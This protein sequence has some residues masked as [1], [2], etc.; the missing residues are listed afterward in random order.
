MCRR[1]SDR[2][3]R[4]AWNHYQTTDIYVLIVCTYFIKWMHL[5]EDIPTNCFNLRA[6]LMCSSRHTIDFVRLLLAWDRLLALS[7]SPSSHFLPVPPFICTVRR[8]LALARFRRCRSPVE[9]HWMIEIAIFVQLNCGVYAVAS[10][11]S[12]RLP[13]DPI[14][15]FLPISV[16]VGNVTLNVAHFTE[17]RFS[18]F[19]SHDVRR[20]VTAVYMQ[21]CT[22]VLTSSFLAIVISLCEWKTR[23]TI[24]IRKSEEIIVRVGSLIH[25]VCTSSAHG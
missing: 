9:A 11:F 4:R 6:V 21:V 18:I 14:R 8:V 13:I 22:T 7:V 12:L 15:S 1:P 2:R 23:K 17:F 16:L 10:L 19:T 25:A 20:I 24:L 3:C 5:I